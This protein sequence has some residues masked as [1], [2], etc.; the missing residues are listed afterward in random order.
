MS[1]KRDFKEHNEKVL[2]AKCSLFN[3][4]SD[5]CEYLRHEK[6]EDDIRVKVCGINDGKGCLFKLCPKLNNKRGKKK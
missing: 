2:K 5:N 1:T 6:R 3:K 4:T